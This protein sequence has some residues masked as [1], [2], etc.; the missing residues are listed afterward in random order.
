MNRLTQRLEELSE[1]SDAEGP[2]QAGGVT[3]LLDEV[4]DEVDRALGVEQGESIEARVGGV[5][6][7]RIVVVLTMTLIALGAA[8]SLAEAQGASP[9]QRI[10]SGYAISV[11]CL[12]F[13]AFARYKD[14]PSRHVLLG[15]G[16]A[17]LYMTSYAAFFFPNM[18]VFTE[19]AAAWPLL[20]TCLVLMIAFSHLIRSPVAAGISLFTVYYTVI[21]SCTYARSSSTFYYAIIT[22]AVCSLAVSLLHFHHR[23]RALTWTIMA[24]TY[25]VFFVFFRSRPTELLALSTRDYTCSTGAV[26]TICFLVFAAACISDARQSKAFT[27]TTAFMAIL[28]PLA[29]LVWMWGPLRDSFPHLAWVFQLALAGCLVVFAALSETTGST[30]NLPFQFFTA[31]TVL[32]FLAALHGLLSP[33][34]I[35]ISFALVGFVLAIVYGWTAIVILKILSLAVLGIT[36]SCCIPEISLPGGVL[37]FG[38]SLPANWFCC[39]GVATVFLATSW[40]YEHADSLRTTGGRTVSGQWFLADTVFDVRTTTAAMLFSATAALLILTLTVFEFADQPILPFILGLVGFGMLLVG[41][42]AGIPHAY[43]AAGIVQVAAHITYQFLLFQGVAP[44]A[45]HPDSFVWHCLF[46]AST[47]VVAQ[48]WE[49]YLDAVGG[50]RRVLHYGVLVLPALLGTW[51]LAGVLADRFNG[52]PV[53]VAQCALGS[54]I[55]L[56][57]GIT[58][59]TGLKT[60]GIFATGI[61]AWVCL[62]GLYQSEMS[63]EASLESVPMLAL[64]L[65]MIALSERI[66]YVFETRGKGPSHLEDALRAVLVATAGALGILALNRW[67]PDRLLTLCWLGQAVLGMLLG[68][69]FRESRYRWAALL[70]FAVAI[71]R[72]FLYDLRTLS[73]PHQVLSFAGLLAVVLIVSRGYAAHRARVAQGPHREIEGDVSNGR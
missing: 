21:A 42:V 30:R 7:S 5:W 40:Y 19:H 68:V 34:K 1:D 33:S 46:G 23:W 49:R 29:Y 6:F 59:C 50:P 18:R 24:A 3:H 32:L 27:R 10:F 64:L 26:L 52:L 38:F 14:H 63:F 4:R 69:L 16:L 70:I 54:G 48:F 65:L 15:T 41:V 73:L 44:L 11:I 39:G 62:K 61:G 9:W 25:A 45:L 37:L 28:N 66:V 22:C 53:A 58:A 51:Q 60:G 12:L 36:F 47:L 13:A 17:S 57:G 55:L 20:G 71:L 56:I 2:E 31:M 67:A 8:V 35:W 43:V 72:G